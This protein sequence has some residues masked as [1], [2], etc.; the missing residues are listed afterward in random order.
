MFSCVQI[1]GRVATGNQAS[2]SYIT[3]ARERLIGTMGRPRSD[4]IDTLAIIA[5]LGTGMTT[6][7]K[8]YQDYASEAARPYARG[9]A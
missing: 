2:Y 4:P 1:V 9:R 5:D 6:R 3:I 8:A 7:L